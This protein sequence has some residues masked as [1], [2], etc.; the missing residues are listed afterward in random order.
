MEPSREIGARRGCR[1][2]LGGLRLTLSAILCYAS[3]SLIP[4]RTRAP[5]V[6]VAQAHC[7]VPLPHQ[8]TS[9]NEPI[10]SGR[11]GGSCRRLRPRFA[12][13]TA[14]LTLPQCRCPHQPLRPRELCPARLGQGVRRFDS[15]ARVAPVQRDKRLHGWAWLP[16]VASAGTGRRLS[17]EWGAASPSIDLQGYLSTG[18]FLHRETARWSLS[19]S[20]EGWHL[21]GRSWQSVGGGGA[22]QS[23]ARAG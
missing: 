14:Y 12:S 18:G 13:A 2:H 5:L 21:R 11:N 16:G 17:R 7:R 20:P 9:K 8:G 3:Y 23:G 22:C 1:R 15:C 4:R 6:R 10:L 19:S